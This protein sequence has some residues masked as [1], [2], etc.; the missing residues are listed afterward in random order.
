LF[1][2]TRK[3]EKEERRRIELKKTV[4][5]GKEKEERRRIELKKTV[6]KGKERKGESVKKRKSSEKI[7]GKRN[8]RF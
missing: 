6:E 2:N 8:K 3:Q 7:S 5:K 1:R 4:E